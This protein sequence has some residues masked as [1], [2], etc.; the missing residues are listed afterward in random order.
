M[1]KVIVN[2]FSRDYIKNNHNTIVDDYTAL[3]QQVYALYDQEK[4]YIYALKVE[5]KTSTQSKCGY[6]AFP[7]IKAK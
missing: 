2:I 3:T 4:E 7:S 1:K 6:F 5:M